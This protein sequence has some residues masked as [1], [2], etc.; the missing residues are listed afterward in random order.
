MKN[1]RLCTL[2]MVLVL[3]TILNN[4]YSQTTTPQNNVPPAATPTGHQV[5]RPTDTLGIAEVDL[6]VTQCY[7]L[8]DQT[9]RMSTQLNA[10]N[11][12]VL[13]NK[14]SDIDT[15]SV[16]TQL[17]TFKAQMV[18]LRVDG[19]NLLQSSSA[20]TDKVSDKLKNKPF[21]IPGA[22][23]RVKN[24]T[25]AVK[26]SAQTIYTMSTV[27]L[28]S[29]NKKLNIHSAA[30]SSQAK[31]A[32]NSAQAMPTTGKTIKT[33]ISITGIGYTA[34]NSLSNE[35]SSI[36]SIKSTSKKFNSSGKSEID[37]VHYG[38]TDDLL[39]AMLANCKDIVT[40]KNI[41]GSE[42]GKINLVFSN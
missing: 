29:I 26:I 4:V 8:Y 12:Q 37:V 13:V 20:M 1:N 39:N 25:K 3:M 31:M 18:T 11:Q 16:E 22:I 36:S 32:N 19:N 6:Y 33:S 30:D 27:T 17:N 35:L 34:F 41:G 5:T 21:K 10:I 15:K 42:K 28:V 7:D 2:A 38:T 40:D 24:A 23:I 9:Q 14:T